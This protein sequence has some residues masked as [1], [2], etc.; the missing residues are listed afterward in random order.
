ME[1]RNLIKN[2]VLDQL[3]ICKQEFFRVR[4]AKYNKNNTQYVIHIVK[5]N[6][7]LMIKYG[8]Y[9]YYFCKK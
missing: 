8:L 5:D 6:F 4:L 3:N 1:K 2:L 7:N 9:K